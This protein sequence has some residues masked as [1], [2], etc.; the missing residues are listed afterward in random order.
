M[1]QVVG[2]EG[3]RMVE[4]VT[5]WA[6][7][8]FAD[9]IGGHATRAWQRRK[10]MRLASTLRPGSEIGERYSTDSGW[11]IRTFSP[12]LDATASARR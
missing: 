10:L 12:A 7:A 4:P 8:Y 2:Q 1:I 3:C 11:Y 5:A 6:A 9:R